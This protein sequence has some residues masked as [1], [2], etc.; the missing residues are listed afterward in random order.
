[1]YVGIHVNST[2]VGVLPPCSLALGWVCLIWNFADFAVGRDANVDLLGMLA[3]Q[4]S[5]HHLI[6]SHLIHTL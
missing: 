5:A 6:S 1:M 4:Q 3:A 2:L